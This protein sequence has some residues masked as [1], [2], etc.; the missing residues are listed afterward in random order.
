MSIDR[1]NQIKGFIE[2]ITFQ[3]DET[4]FTVARLKEKGRRELT[5]IVGNMPSI[6]EGE[7]IVCQGF[8]KNDKRHGWQF[9]VTDYDVELP[10][11]VAGIQKYLASGMI[12]GIG[13]VFA[14]RIVQYFGKETL[15]VIDENPD[16]LVEVNGIGDKRVETIKTYWKEQRAIRDVMMFLQSQGISPMYAQKIYKQYGDHSITKIQA[17][18]YHLSRDIYGI[19]F[20]TA[21][22]IAQKLGIT[23]EADERIDAGVEFV[24]FELSNQGHTC[25]PVDDFVKS[26]EDLLDVPR[27][28]IQERLA[29][30]ELNYRI[31]VEKLPDG[32]DYIWLMGIYNAEKGI[33][34]TLK[35][36]LGAPL[37]FQVQNVATN[38]AKTEKALQIQLAANQK[39]AVEQSV[40]KKI[41]IITGGPGTGKSTI[42]KVILKIT[43]SYT[44]KILLAAPTGR[45][46]KR[47]SQVTGLNA[48]TIHSLLEFDFSI[49]GFKRNATNPLD[50]EMIIVDEAS[51]IDTM[52]MFYLLKAVPFNAI[53]V[54]IGDI[55]QLPS[56]GAGNVL[57]DFI[58]SKHIPVTRLT[59][60]FRQAASSKIITSAHQIN[61]GQMPNLRI[62]KESDFF[63]I[64][65]EEI[66]NIN[67]TIQDLLETRL[68]KRY[69]FDPFND[70][71]VLSPM[72]RG[73]IGTHQLNEALQN[74]LNPSYEPLQKYGRRFHKRDKV[75]QIVNNYD[76]N[77]FNGDVGRVLDIDREE[78]EML[79]KFD[80]QVVTYDFAELD[81]LT[82]A[83]AVSVHKY[84]GSECP[85][86][87]MPV[88]TTHYTMLFKNLIYTGITRGKK[89]VV[90]IGTKKAMAIAIRNN[91]VQRRYTGLK[92]I[93]ENEMKGG[94]ETNIGL[95]GKAVKVLDWKTEMK[96][97]DTF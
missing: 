39:V 6:Q 14:E 72:K 15:K 25:Y 22:K 28:R 75:M 35:K 12:K 62:E 5:V 43:Q 88:H 8:W 48:Q 32:K 68:P 76:K 3:S 42:T 24:L 65:E 95:Y 97:S 92:Y 52:L 66:E 59:E 44:K 85:C 9:Q 50:A 63:F 46:A 96:V 67:T 16:S 60:I 79:V 80:Q 34:S 23:K 26:A 37:A 58:A 49:N 73:H 94:V 86:I 57:R 90:V 10:S 45:A 1:N 56:V 18:P 2:R 82:L 84:Q 78:Q 19:G 4:G 38:I 21:D 51:M 89:L 40:Q 17:N 30:I 87:V 83:Y 41:H 13:S 55:D 77:I 69:G 53:L 47:L 71:Q 36:L 74:R 27:D 33:V 54:F 31:L 61:R 70:I 7:V 20:K 81:Q 93:L 29:E 11:T 91:R 64:Q